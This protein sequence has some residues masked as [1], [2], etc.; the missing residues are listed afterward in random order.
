VA[1]RA[2][3]AGT[4][5]PELPLVQARA[6]LL[7]EDEPAA[8]RH[9]ATAREI[10]P[11]Y[12][13]G[14]TLELLLDR[15][16]GRTDPLESARRE[17]LAE[18]AEGRAK[19]DEWPDSW[20]EQALLEAAFEPAASPAPLAALDRAITLGFRDADLLLVDPFAA[21]LRARRGFAARVE[22]IRQL[23]AAEAR[24]VAGAPWLPAGLLT[25]NAA[26]R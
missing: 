24:G 8:R 7:A 22:R 25:G 23:G 12:A 3:A 15:R 1:A 14:R 11:R 9:L 6:A 20:L 5:R 13:F 26:S 18:L 21:E 17:R 2:L 19:G 4:R 10:N 16:T